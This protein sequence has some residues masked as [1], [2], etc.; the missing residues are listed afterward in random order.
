MAELS[1]FYGIIIYMYGFDHPPPHFHF[2]YGEF[3]C[4]MYIKDLIIEGKA[5]SKVVKKVEQW[6]KTNQK[7]LLEVWEMAQKGE[8]LPKI[9]P[10]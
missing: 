7:K 10:L 5:P 9:K 6:T 1:R 3:E 2:I 8:P 4:I